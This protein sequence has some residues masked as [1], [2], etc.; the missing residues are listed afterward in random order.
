MKLS[1]LTTR[2]QALAASK[3]P[4]TQGHYAI[5]GRRLL[6]DLGNVSLDRITPGKAADW[7]IGL[8]V[9]A[10]TRAY[11]VRYA[12]AIFER[13]VREKLIESNPFEHESSREDHSAKDWPY[14]DDAIMGKLLDA[15]PSVQ[16]KRLI[17]L[18]RWAGLRASEARELQ[19]SD[20]T[21]QTASVLGKGGKRRL[22]PLKPQ[23]VELLAHGCLE[24]AG[25]CDSLPTGS[26]LSQQAA[27][28]A[29]KAGFEK[30]SPL[31]DL[32]KC[33]VMD[34]VRAYGARRA[35]FAM[36]H[37]AAVS[38]VHYDRLTPADLAEMAR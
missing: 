15:C 29:L 18:C 31:H 11:Y 38:I 20:I 27:H 21:D 13:A 22:V 1:T 12:K 9:S 25:P 16:W 37:S 17:A 7:A 14:Y 23:V 30:S 3:S 34:C 10:N 8:D 6:A 35:G 36:G 2:C 5:V 33:A 4:A 26:L 28:I 32:R 19:W 24:T